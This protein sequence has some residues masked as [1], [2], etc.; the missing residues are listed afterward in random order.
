MVGLTAGVS[1]NKTLAVVSDIDC[2]RGILVDWTLRTHAQDVF[3]AGDCAELEND[4]DERNVIQQVWYTGKAQGVQAAESILGSDKK[5]VPDIW[6]NSAK[7]LDIEYQ[8]YG[9]VGFRLPGEEHLVWQDKK[10]SRLFRIVHIDN[11]VVGFN[12]MGM[13]WRHR[14]CEKWLA[15]KWTV[16]QVLGDLADAGFDPEFYKRFESEIAQTMSGAR[17]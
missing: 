3:A 13:R 14:V 10:A 2:G 4:G 5:Y 6:F 9:Q 17:S 8:T 12:A 7:F 15:E 16:D 1:P 11:I